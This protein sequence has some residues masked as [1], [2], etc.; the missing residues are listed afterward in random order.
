MISII[1]D[2]QPTAVYNQFDLYKTFE[3]NKP[4]LDGSIEYVPGTNLN[5]M[6]SLAFMENNLSI[7]S[8]AQRKDMEKY[9]E[10]SDGILSNDMV[11]LDTYLGG[12]VNA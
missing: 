9:I 1:T 10:Q 3:T 5:E 7:L 6:F 11:Q 12:L 4:R 8:K 2:V